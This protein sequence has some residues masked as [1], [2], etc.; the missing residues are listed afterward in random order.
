MSDKNSDLVAVQQQLIALVDNLSRQ[1][2]EAQT[3]DAVKAI[4]REIVEVNHRVTMVGQLVFKERTD[5]IKAAVQKVLK[6]KQ[7]VDDAIESIQR[8]NAFITTITQFLGL[9]DKVIDTAKLVA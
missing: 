6:G 9:V 4:G 1:Q 5:E 8:L 2:E 7:A 3:V